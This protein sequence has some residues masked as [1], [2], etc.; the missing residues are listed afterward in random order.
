MTDNEEIAIL[1]GAA[2]VDLTVARDIVVGDQ[3]PCATSRE[4]WLRLSSIEDFLPGVWIEMRYATSLFRRS[5]ASDPPLLDAGR[6]IQ[7]RACAGPLRGC[8]RLDW[9]RAA[10]SL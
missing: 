2:G 1:G 9:S 4:P 10:Q 3:G 5:G 6:R 7:G 8:G